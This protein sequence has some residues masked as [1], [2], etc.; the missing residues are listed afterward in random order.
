V[1][2]RV[3]DTDIH[4]DTFTGAGVAP[5]QPGDAVTLALPPEAC[6]VLDPAG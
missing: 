4:Y 2:V 1:Q 6:L 5:P 3:A